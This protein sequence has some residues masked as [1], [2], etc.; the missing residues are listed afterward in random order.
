MG[1]QQSR[2]EDVI[3]PTNQRVEDEELLNIQGDA[4]EVVPT[5]HHDSREEK[6][7]GGISHNTQTILEQISHIA[8]YESRE[9]LVED[10]I[11]FLQKNLDF[12]IGNNIR[13]TYREVLNTMKYPTVSSYA[14][15]IRK[16][17]VKLNDLVLLSVFT[18]IAVHVHRLDH[19]QNMPVLVY[20]INARPNVPQKCFHV[21]VV[22]K[23]FFTHMN[24][25]PIIT[26]DE[27]ALR[28]KNAV[29]LARFKNALG[30]KDA[31][32][33]LFTEKNPYAV[34]GALGVPEV[35]DITFEGKQ[36]PGI[37]HQVG[38]RVRVAARS[39]TGRG[40]GCGK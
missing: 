5:Q 39:L 26:A 33:A 23:Y 18:D 15:H 36:A 3:I 38:Q 8:G 30:D 24:A 13:G 22:G 27:A 11:A 29:L 21:T 16:N 40:C 6:P 10:F 35:D 34:Q 20:S 32:P 9:K 12:S 19:A 7:H 14:I 2:S 31:T 17:R 37:R 1:S 4:L 28:D 25:H